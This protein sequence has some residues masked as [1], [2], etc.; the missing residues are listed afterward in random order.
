MHVT[1][2]INLFSLNTKKYFEM[3]V[4]YLPATTA[5]QDSSRELN[6][7]TYFMASWT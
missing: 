7:E 6:L 1:G 4:N 2:L 5:R 3:C